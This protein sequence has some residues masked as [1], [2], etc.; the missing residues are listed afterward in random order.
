MRNNI[1]GRFDSI[2]IRIT[3]IETLVKLVAAEI[4]IAIALLI[5]LVNI[6]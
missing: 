5:L 2:E 3:K 4:P 1:E 6:M